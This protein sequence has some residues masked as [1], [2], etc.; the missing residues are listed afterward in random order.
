MERKC[1][2]FYSKN[3]IDSLVIASEQLQKV[4]GDYSN[5]YYEA[6]ADVA[7]VY[8]AETYSVNKLYNKAILHLNNA[9]NT[10]LKDKSESKKIFYAKA[11]VLSTFANVYMDKNEPENAVRKLREEIRSGSEIKN[12]NKFASFQ[13]HN[14]A[15]ISNA[16]TQIFQ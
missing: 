1:R 6:M 11:N 10:L 2:Y 8:L 3:Q 13:Y 9:Y 16:Y 4:S 15:N 5:E 14:Y 12:K 7:D